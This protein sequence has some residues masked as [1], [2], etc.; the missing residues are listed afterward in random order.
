MDYGQVL[1]LLPDCR[2]RWWSWVILLS[3]V[4][5][6]S[7]LF[8]AFFLSFFVLLSTFSMP[9]HSSR[10]QFPSTAIVMWLRGGLDLI[11]T[12][13]WIILLAAEIWCHS[14]H[15]NLSKFASILESTSR[16]E[17]CWKSYM[18]HLGK[19]LWDVCSGGHSHYSATQARCLSLQLG[20]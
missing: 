8:A 19:C 20:I 17:I 1:S 4:L 10:F 11:I 7:S 14:G 6:S 5:S 15:I 12:L 9:S 2:W 3:S 18:G 16:W 13:L